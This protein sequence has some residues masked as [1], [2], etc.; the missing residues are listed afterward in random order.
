MRIS[1]PKSFLP[2]PA[3]L[4]VERIKIHN[5]LIAILEQGVLTSNL[6]VDPKKSLHVEETGKTPL[7]SSEPQNPDFRNLPLYPHVQQ[8]FSWLGPSVFRRICGT[9]KQCSIPL[10]LESHQTLGIR[11]RK[12][13]S[14]PQPRTN[15]LS[16]GQWGSQESLGRTQ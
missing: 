12:E 2:L 7:I 14:H 1:L 5:G 10:V 9:F 11:R 6:S 13:R 3:T 15:L 8:A 16:Y 4:S